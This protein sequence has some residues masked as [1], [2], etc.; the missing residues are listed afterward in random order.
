MSIQE[1]FD[2]LEEET[3]KHHFQPYYIFNVGRTIKLK[4]AKQFLTRVSDK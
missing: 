4:T 3:M 2:L 1:T